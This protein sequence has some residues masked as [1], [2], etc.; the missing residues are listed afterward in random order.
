MHENLTFLVCIYLVIRV[1]V[2]FSHH[3]FSG[4][5]ADLWAFVPFFF[6]FLGVGVQVVPEA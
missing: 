5:L 1:N 6:F 4:R 3:S 2:H